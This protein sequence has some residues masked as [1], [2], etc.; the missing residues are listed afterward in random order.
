MVLGCRLRIAGCRLP[1]ADCRLQI[2]GCC[3]PGGALFRE[4]IAER[5][6]DEVECQQ[7]QAHAGCGKGKKPPVALDRVERLRS[8]A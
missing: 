5:I 1:V 2:A 3:S 6:T 7:R 4:R 8:I